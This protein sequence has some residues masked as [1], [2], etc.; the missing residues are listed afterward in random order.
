MMDELIFREASLKDLPAMKALYRDTI[1][2][3]CRNDYTEAELQVWA[4][5]VHKEERWLNMVTTQYVCLAEI[6][7][8]LVGFASL[9]EHCYIDFFYVHHQYQ[10]QGI[11]RALLVQLLHEAEAQGAVLLSSDISKTARPFFESQ[12]FCVVAEQ[13][14]SRESQILVNY[15]MIRHLP[16]PGLNPLLKGVFVIDGTFRI[17]G[18][19]LILAGK[20]QEGEVYHGDSLLFSA[21]GKL[22]SR[23]VKGVEMT[24]R[25]Q[26]GKIGVL[27]KPENDMEFEELFNWKPVNDIA[28]IYSSEKG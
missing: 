10:G 28:L 22:L 24:S 23:L 13:E 14:N 9:K 26:Q 5:S 15:K 16:G 6:A 2:T 27:I 18:R 17:T 3:V 11:A 25:S 19:G 20:M 7:E 8:T 21:N 4:S 12:G 1:L